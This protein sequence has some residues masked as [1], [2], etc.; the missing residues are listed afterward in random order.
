M[1][2]RKA[3]VAPF[4]A[5]LITVIIGLGGVVLDLSQAYS[6]KAKIKNAVDAAVLASI[7]QLITN[8]DTTNGKNVALN[9]LNSNLT[10]TINSFQP[11]TLSSEGLSIQVGVYDF[12]TMTFTTNEESPGINAIMV[13]YNYNYSTFL[14]NIFMINNF[15]ISDQAVAAKQIAGKMAPGGGFPLAL[16]YMV[17]SDAKLNN[18]MIDLVQSGVANSFFTAFMN[19]TAS[20]NDTKDIINYFINQNTGMSPPE[21]SVGE[22]FQINNGS[23]T[24]VYMS[25]DP[26]CFEGMTFVSPIVRLQDGFSNTVQVE[27][28]VG[29]TINDI[30]KVGNDYHVAGTIIP[31]YIDNHWSGLTIAAGPGNIPQEDQSLLATSF[32]LVL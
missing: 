14:A 12:N 6:I 16:E 8:S 1:R 26:I 27:G 32:A 20:A 29:F 24:T 5:L 4:F 2:N 15:Q 21:L 30:Y 13:S 31:S 19:D 11:L 17:L 9:F 10:N 7:S 3:I 28:F 25:L 18:N 22:I 23:L